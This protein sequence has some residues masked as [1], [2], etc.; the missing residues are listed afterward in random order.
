M[1]IARAKQKQG[2]V[3]S[4]CPIH[5][6]PNRPDGSPDPLYGY[7]P[8]INAI[9]NRLKASL[10]TQCLP[11]KLVAD[12]T[13]A[14][15]CLILV[16]LQGDGSCLNPTCDPIQGLT[17]PPASVLPK[18]CQVQEDAWKAGGGANS[19]VPDP[20]RQNVCQLKQLIK[21]VDMGAF[22]STGSC[23]EPMEPNQ[24]GWCYVEG[25]AAS[26][27][28]Q[29]IVFTRN[30]PPHGSTANLHCIE[31]AVSVVGGGVGGGAAS[32]GTGGTPADDSGT[33]AVGD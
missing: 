4:L 11:Q 23:A 1:I 9:V 24:L 22:D 6:T 7:R 10:N 2:I 15:P 13:G 29:A 27:C 30:E 20:L 28:P 33:P 18:F 19:T 16:T 21:G 25:A 3:S 32:S 8:A 14:V 17:A 12:N 26:G 5:L 31:Q